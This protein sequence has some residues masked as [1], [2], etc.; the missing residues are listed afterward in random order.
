MWIGF[1]EQRELLLR[2]AREFGISLDEHLRDGRLVVRTL[3]PVENDP[4]EI[5]AIIRHAVETHGARRQVIDGLFYLERATQREDRAYDFF[6]AL[7]TYLAAASVATCAIKTINRVGAE[8][9]DFQ[10]TPLSLMAKNLL[11]LRLTRDDHR[12]RRTLTVLARA[13]GEP[14]HRVYTY[15]IKRS[16]LTIEGPSDRDT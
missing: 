2:K 1:D 15:S 4:D 6:G 9:L 12:T 5:A 11:W 14:N 16:G 8:E 7:T 13:D 3:A 10:D